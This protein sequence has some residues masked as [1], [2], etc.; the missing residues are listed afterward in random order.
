[1]PGILLIQIPELRRTQNICI[2]EL[3]M[4]RA[5]EAVCLGAIIS[6]VSDA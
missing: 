4:L 3:E 2:D 6:S 5:L 1:M